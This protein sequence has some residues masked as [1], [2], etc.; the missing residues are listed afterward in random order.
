LARPLLVV[1]A[2]ELSLSGYLFCG[3]ILPLSLGE[4]C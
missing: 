3:T 1:T 4:V 2:R